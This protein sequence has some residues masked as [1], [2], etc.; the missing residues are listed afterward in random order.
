[1]KEEYTDAIIV[2]ND[3]VTSEMFRYGGKEVFQQM[4]K[5]MQEIWGKEKMPRDWDQAILCLVYKEVKS[6]IFMDSK[7]QEE[8]KE[9]CNEAI[10]VENDGITSEMFGCGGKQLFQQTHKLMQG[11][12]V[13]EEL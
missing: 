3:G 12:W 13:Q 8:P 7:N 10:L 4:Y 6:W 5:L 9:E 2:E 1:M 11:I